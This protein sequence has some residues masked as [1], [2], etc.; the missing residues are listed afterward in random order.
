[1][2]TAFTAYCA[3][4]VPSFNASRSDI[5]NF[6]VPLLASRQTSFFP[7]Q[8]L[9]SFQ[10]RS[11]ASKRSFSARTS[12]KYP[13]FGVPRLLA[14][15]TLDQSS[16]DDPDSD[17]FDPSKAIAEIGTVV[18]PPLRESSQTE[19]ILDALNSPNGRPSIFL[20]DTNIVIFYGKK[21]PGK[22]FQGIKPFIDSMKKKGHRF[23][24][25]PK[26]RKEFRRDELPELFEEFNPDPTG[27]EFLEECM[28]EAFELL[29]K[30]L[31]LSKADAALGMENDMR[32]IW[33]AGFDL[34]ADI[35]PIKIYNI[36]FLTH[37][38]KLF[39]NFLRV[40]KNVDAFALATERVGLQ[41]MVRILWIQD[42]V[43]G[44]DMGS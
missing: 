27:S 14:F 9:F 16:I 22:R 11:F 39:K 15:A 5:S 1:M 29:V 24:I 42:L 8:A 31:H 41:R 30:W 28:D 7:R 44:I 40:K 36:F 37:N 2:A 4:S 3:Q 25:T 43:V 32:I 10:Q 23:L 12:I 38:M 19:L 18:V 13:V 34:P 35:D 20:V 17:S 33:E 26:A 21:N 6:D